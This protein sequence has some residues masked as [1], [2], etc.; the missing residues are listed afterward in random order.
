MGLIVDVQ[1]MLHRKLCVTLG[2]GE[3]LVAQHFLNGA[4]VRSFFQ[5]VRAES[6]AQ[7]VGVDIG[8]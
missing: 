7:S 4:Q 5:H 6:V 8:R 1:Y 2:S 3:T